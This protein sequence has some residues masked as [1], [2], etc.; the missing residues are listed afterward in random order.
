MRD[1]SSVAKA[2]S[3]EV[4]VFVDVAVLIVL[5]PLIAMS[6]NAGMG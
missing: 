1:D 6:G 4:R 2:R 3:T 5:S